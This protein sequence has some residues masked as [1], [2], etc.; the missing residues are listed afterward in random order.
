MATGES[1]FGG[2]GG[3]IQPRQVGHE[4]EEQQLWE[5]Y[6]TN[7]ASTGPDSVPGSPEN[8]RNVNEGTRPWEEIKTDAR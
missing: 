7:P 3:M 1:E 6:A 2:R 5:I 4:T 8:V